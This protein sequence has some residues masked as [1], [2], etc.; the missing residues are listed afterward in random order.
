MGT[1]NFAASSRVSFDGSLGAG[2][3]RL[4]ALAFGA[5]GTDAGGVEGAAVQWHAPGMAI[6]E[7]GEVALVSVVAE[8][9]AQ[10]APDPAEPRGKRGHD[11]CVAT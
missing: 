3:S 10:P 6:P 8:Q 5:S 2:A 7:V 1:D 11:S 9:R 4:I